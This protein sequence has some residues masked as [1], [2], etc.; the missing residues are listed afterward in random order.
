VTVWWEWI[1]AFLS[2]LAAIIGSTFTIKQ[3]SVHEQQA[4]DLRLAA[5]R[6]GLDRERAREG[7]EP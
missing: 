5:F 7:A 6:E 2:A 4:C 1:T 3:V